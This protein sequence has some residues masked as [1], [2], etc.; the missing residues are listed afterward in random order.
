MDAN[1]PNSVSATKPCGKPKN[2]MQGTRTHTCK[3][4]LHNVLNLNEPEAISTDLI[5]TAKKI[6]N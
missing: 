4:M 5:W 6:N 3:D 2:K 1:C